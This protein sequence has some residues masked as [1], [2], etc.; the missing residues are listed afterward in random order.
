MSIK[1]N[2]RNGQQFTWGIYHVVYLATDRADNTATCEFDVIV[3]PE[4]CG[5]PMS[6][7]SIV[8]NSTRLSDASYLKEQVNMMSV[9]WCNGE[10][11]V[12]TQEKPPFYV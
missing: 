3:S 2:F 4:E 9:I 11:Y 5:D 6:T 10:N 1:S 7:T 8:V 12:F